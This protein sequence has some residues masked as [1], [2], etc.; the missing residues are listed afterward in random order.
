MDKD[1]YV[2]IK[3]ELIEA[4]YVGVYQYSEP[5]GESPMIGGHPGGVVAYPLAVVKIDGKLKE[6]SLSSITFKK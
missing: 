4:E 1:C 5:I 6:V 2:T 3:K